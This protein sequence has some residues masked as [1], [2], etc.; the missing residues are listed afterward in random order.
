[1]FPLGFCLAL[2]VAA[3]TGQEMLK[4]PGMDSMAN[5][6]CWNIN[7]DLSTDKHSG[8]HAIHATNRHHFYD[9]PS[10]T[11][12]VSPGKHY[13]VEAWAKVSKDNGKGQ[14]M[15]LEV[16]NHLPNGHSSYTT[17]SSR[18]SLRTSSGWI[19]LFG[20]YLAPPGVKNIK[21][22]FQGPEPGAEFIADAASMTPL[23]EGSGDWKTH[24]NARIDSLRKHNVHIKVSNDAGFDKNG[25][26]IEVVQNKHLFPF[27]T[28]VVAHIM[29]KNNGGSDQKYRQFVYDH[30]NWAVT[31]NAMKWDQM[32]RT[33]GHPNYDTALNAVK[34]LRSH[35]LKVRAH[36][37]IWADERWVPA[38][39]KSKSAGEVKSLVDKHVKE[40]VTKFKGL[41]E[42]WDVNNEMLHNNW[43]IRKTGD[44]DFTKKVFR[45]VHQYDP[46]V[47]LFLNDF[48]VVAGSDATNA[49]VA[50]GKDYKSSGT[51]VAGMG[52]Q[53]HFWQIPDPLVVK[54][55][56]D[57]LSEVGLPIW[58]TELDIK[59]PD[60]HKRAD[61]YENV[62]RM[63]FSHPSV[64]GIMF[65]GF[66]SQHHW[67]GEAA[68]LVSGPE[69]RI[70]AAGERFLK[71]MSQDWKTYDK[72][73]L[74]RGSTYSV[75][76]F[77]GDYDVYIKRNGQVIQ[78][79][80]FSVG[81]SDYN[82]NLHLSAH[83]Y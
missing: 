26:T 49:Y 58:V 28:A 52:A 23:G 67:A 14:K 24:A 57:I 77:A 61:A 19:K 17:V 41:V 54:Q 75:R 43:Y 10:Q 7:C 55:R 22:Y 83:G 82:F 74:T 56:L 31:E 65:W 3:V 35:G 80:H 48:G 27:G 62:L 59:E 20:I 30:F 45:E 9:G 12:N 15:T 6:D 13:N 53:C 50:Q 47:K 46:H 44:H 37:L 4:N 60:E 11:V 29:N 36:N 39:L 70:N 38:W 25:V 34:K 8:S 40:T 51:Y 5:W 71:L 33:E 73:Q 18:N 63:L 76:A 81:N 79:E 16:E 72:H 69:F 1:M 32:E 68:S 64:H 66:W 2:V 42:H 21:V 78:T